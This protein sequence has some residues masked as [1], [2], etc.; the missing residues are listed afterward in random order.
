MVGRLAT[1]GMNKQQRSIKR[2]LLVFNFLVPIAVL[3]PLLEKVR[4]AAIC[5]RAPSSLN[6][7]I[8]YYQ[9]TC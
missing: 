7:W 6:H 4:G 2:L 1:L 5:H 8:I 9:Y 3:K